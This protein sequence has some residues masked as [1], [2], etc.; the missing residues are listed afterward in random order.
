MRRLLVSCAMAVLW[1]VGTGP[2]ASAAPSDTAEAAKTCQSAYASLGFRN[3][4][5]CVSFFARGGT[6]ATGSP[7][8]TLTFDTAPCYNFPS[9]SCMW[10]VE[11]AGLAPGSTVTV[12][13]SGVPYGAELMVGADG[14][15]SV[16]GIYMIGSCVMPGYELVDFIA[17]GLAPGGAPVESTVVS[18]DISTV[19]PLC[20]P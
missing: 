20:A 7:S 10:S 12:G 6:I 11:G 17:R 8:L 4:G 9:V 2:V 16:H 15:V 5:Q 13:D 18:A 3:A 1:C 14:T 19:M